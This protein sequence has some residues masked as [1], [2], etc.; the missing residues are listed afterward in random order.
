MSGCK[1][2]N[3]GC[4]KNFP[5]STA[6]FC[7]VCGT[8][9]S[10]ALAP[11]LLSSSS[12]PKFVPTVNTIA[13]APP[14]PTGGQLHPYS[15][16]QVQY[17]TSQPHF[18]NLKAG[19]IADLSA[20]RNS[21]EQVTITSAL[22]AVGGV[23]TGLAVAILLWHVYSSGYDSNPVGAFFVGVISIGALW[24]LAF[25]Y[26]DYV[27]ASTSAIQIAVPILF[28]VM[29]Y[30]K[31][32][33]GEIGLPSLLIGIVFAGFWA[34]P[35]LRA[36]P[37]LLASA[38]SWVVTGFALILVQSNIEASF[39]YDDLGVNFLEV[40][41]SAA[42]LVIMLFGIGILAAGWNLERKSWP[43]VA[44]AFIA[45]GIY[46]AVV[47]AGGYLSS[48]SSSDGATLV[49]IAVLGIALVLIGG[50]ANRRATTWIGATILTGGFLEIITTLV[51]DR[52]DLELA[53]FM[54]VM[55]GLVGY[56]GNKYGQAIV[57]RIR[58][59]NP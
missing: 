30:S 12:V 3:S 41:A 43:N 58:G 13:S 6:K 16:T 59:N 7:T 34:L 33:N 36:R 25:R 57:A 45:I 20:K 28:L 44:T 42:S 48:G 51:E 29:F 50:S 22:L 38:L 56:L 27:I 14:S 10:L 40:A 19:L 39:Y 32:R 2:D 11:T 23:L 35:G 49:L 1:R 26:S 8:E 5:G 54:A 24:F 4:I 31:I 17:S 15:P 21:R 47:G 37:S 55:G 46:T 53:L 52:T 18:A 9:A